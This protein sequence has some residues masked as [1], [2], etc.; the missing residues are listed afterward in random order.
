MATKKQFIVGGLLL[1]ALFLAGCGGGD[2]ELGPVGPAGPPGPQG[3]AG[4]PG[5]PASAAADFVGSETC[6]ACH[7]VIY[8]HFV[9]SGHAYKL[10]PVVDGQ[11]PEYP[12][13]QVPN[14]PDGY[15]WGDV[16]YVIGGYNWKALF[17]DS[18]GYIITG[19]ENAA[20]Q[21]NLENTM[22]GMG[23]DWV[24]YYA[25]E[26]KPYA[27][28][29]C[30]T[31][32]YRPVGNQDG[33]SGLI[34]TWAEPGIKCEECHGP[35]GYH[36][37][38]PYRVHMK[39][40]RDAESCSQCHSR[41]A[42]EEVD[43]SGGFISHHEQYEELYQSKHLILDCVDCHDPH[44]GVVQLR[45][46][47]QPT[48][49]T[50]CESCHFKEARYSAVNI[51]TS[52]AECIDCHM[53]R[54]TRSALGD[55]NSFT[56]DLRTHV[57]AIDPFQIGQFSADGSISLPQISLD[58]ACRHC[59]VNGTGTEK[60]DEVLIQAADGYHNPPPPPSGEE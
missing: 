50:T 44:T 33:L 20:T 2:G 15:T 40:V 43:A 7:E 22:L 18:E 5:D 31:T 9:Q 10:N 36:I 49:R 52:F 13:S 57:M 41:G 11:P 38:N 16:S 8:T 27:C 3:P 48:V 46:T 51:H 12:F 25:G 24:P 1:I 39:I 17:I 55:T 30:H 37:M 6:A 35:G 56:G 4:P 19:D 32:S 54:V 60:P 34:G 58:F 28:G 29:N 47:D 42:E 53:P 59:H 26:E 23:G 45:K 14:P 21:Y